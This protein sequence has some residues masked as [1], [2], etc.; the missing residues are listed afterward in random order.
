MNIHRI[1]VLISIVL[2]S[3]IFCL[4]FYAY[5]F[6]FP[7]EFAK[8]C[9]AEH[10][11]FTEKYDRINSELNSRITDVMNFVHDNIYDLNDDGKENCMDYSILFKLVWDEKYP[12]L[13]SECEIVHNLRPG[14]MNHLFIRV[15]DGKSE[16]IEIEPWAYNPKLYLMEDNW[17]KVYKPEFNIYGETDLWLEEIKVP[18][19]LGV[20]NK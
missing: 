17:I 18:F 16:D 13:K 15:T 11:D 2:S 5:F 20:S 4:C 3:V 7:W 9:F 14:K 8:A 19:S 12:E 1:Q 6:V 10:H